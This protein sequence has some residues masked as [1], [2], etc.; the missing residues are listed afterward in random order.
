MK[1][2]L[3]FL[4]EIIALKEEHPDYEIKFCVNV[5]NM[6]DNS[7]WMEQKIDRVEICNWYL[8]DDRV[9]VD[10]D[11]RDY[12][13]DYIYENGMAEAELEEMIDKFVAENAVTAICVFTF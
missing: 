11:I 5:E 1:D 4:K 10:G 9:Y 7:A 8:D 12:A 3:A 13:E 2:Q 6:D